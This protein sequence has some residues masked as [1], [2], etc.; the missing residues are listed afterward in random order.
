M[1]GSG[2]DEGLSTMG[3]GGFFTSGK[4]GTGRF[5]QNIRLASFILQ[6]LP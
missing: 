4:A 5:W 1:S 3:L 2:R 6:D